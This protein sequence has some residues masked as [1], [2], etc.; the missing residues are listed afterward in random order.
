MQ[1]FN[2]RLFFSTSCFFENRWHLQWLRIYPIFKCHMFL[3]FC[4]GLSKQRKMPQEMG[5]LHDIQTTL[6]HATQEIISYCKCPV[7]RVSVSTL[8]IQHFLPVVDK[9]QLASGSA[10]SAEH[11][12]INTTKLAVRKFKLT[13]HAMISS[14]WCPREQSHCPPQN[15]VWWEYLICCLIF[16]L[17]FSSAHIIFWQGRNSP[18]TGEAMKDGVK[19]WHAI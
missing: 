5:F 14:I 13:Y 10:N 6:S 19:M 2:P 4:S 9:E 18:R 15:S 8:L 1:G 3:L 11:P 16:F 17:V 12:N 7:A